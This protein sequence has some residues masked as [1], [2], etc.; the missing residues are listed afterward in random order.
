MAFAPLAT[1][2]P[3]M[4]ALRKLFYRLYRGLSYVT[5]PLDAGDFSIMSR[6][7]VDCILLM[8]ERDRFLRGLQ[9][10][11]RLSPNGRAVRQGRALCGPIHQFLAG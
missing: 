3:A 9:K 11:G 6:R 4:E 5:V 2:D 7:V 1:K 8:P 10:L